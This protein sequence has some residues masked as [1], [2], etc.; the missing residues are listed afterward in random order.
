MN[1][2]WDPRTTQD[3]LGGQA[4]AGGIRGRQPLVYEELR[5]CTDLQYRDELI[6]SILR[7]PIDRMAIP[8]RI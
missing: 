4:R 7:S 1:R 2:V 6:P 5:F 8:R 3:P